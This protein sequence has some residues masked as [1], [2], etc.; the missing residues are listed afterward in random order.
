MNVE[1]SD[2][3]QDLFDYIQNDEWLHKEQEQV[4]EYYR[5]WMTS[6]KINHPNIG[7]EIHGWNLIHRTIL[8]LHVEKQYNRVF[9]L[10][11]NFTAR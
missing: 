11:E 6:G 5:N 9:D 7:I 1:Y 10:L 3:Y 8:N 4:R 2:F